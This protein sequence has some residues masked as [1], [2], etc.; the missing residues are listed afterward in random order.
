MHSWEQIKNDFP[1]FSNKGKDFIYLD[2]AATTQKP[3]V[4]IDAICNFYENSNSNVH[5]GIYR[6]SE[7]ATEIYSQ[8]RSAVSRFIGSS[9]PRQIVFVRNATEALNLLAYSLGRSLKAGDEILL[10]IMEHHSNIVPWQFLIDKGVKLKFVDITEDGTLDMDDLDSKLTDRTRI[11]SLTHCSNLLGTINDVSGIA[12][13]VHDNGSLFIVDG[14]QSVPHMPVDVSSID[15]DFLVF[16][17]HKMLGPMG[18]GALYG[19]LHLLEEMSPFNGG[20]EMIREVYQ[21]HSTWADVPEKFEAGTPNVEG[22]VGLMA[23]VNY[24]K[25]IGMDNVR[26]HEKDLIRYTL[27]LEQESR[28]VNLVSY[29]PRDINIR[30]GIYS[31]N[32]GEIRPLNLQDTLMDDNINVGSAVHPHDMASSL[33]GDNISVRSG[34]H[35]AMPLTHRLNV[36]ATSRASYYIYNSRDDVRMLFEAIERISKVYS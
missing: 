5:R 36:V 34:H 20:G 8:S 28:A 4:V 33:D 2:S 14:A 21:D 27:E 19:K 13:K 11:V 18:I 1:I 32:L 31:F 15:C 6:L 12:G 30:G 25:D 23:A 24:L 16:S 3:R 17:G 35:C 29:G 22:A 10:S 7:E 9:D 26:K